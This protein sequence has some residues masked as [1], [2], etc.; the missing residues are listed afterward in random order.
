[1]MWNP[2]IL[3]RVFV[4]I[5]LPARLAHEALHIVTALPFA[6]RV[7]LDIN[8][9]TGNAAARVKWADWAPAPVVTL[10]AL[11]PLIAGCLAALVAVALLLSGAVAV[12]TTVTELCLLAIAA[13]Y[14]AMIA[15]PSPADLQSARGGTDE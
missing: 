5:A 3:Y 14:V 13:S 9:S 11:A 6:R 7:R 12:P 8:V 15:K 10:S 4:L 1:M 2:T